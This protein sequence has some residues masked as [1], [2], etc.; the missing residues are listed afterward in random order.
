ML[1]KPC[2]IWELCNNMQAVCNLPCS[3]LV[4]IAALQQQYSSGGGGAA[5]CPAQCLLT[6][7]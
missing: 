2:V 1:A 5:T 4:L 6:A 7:A 3:A